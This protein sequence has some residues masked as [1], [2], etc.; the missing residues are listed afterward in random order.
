[1]DLAIFIVITLLVIGVLYYY[2]LHLVSEKY[3]AELKAVNK[4][5]FDELVVYIEG[6]LFNRPAVTIWNA[7]L[8]RARMLMD[9]KQ[10]LDMRTRLEAAVWSTAEGLVIDRMQTVKADALNGLRLSA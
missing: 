10:S 4:M 5:S 7:A 3:D 8:G 2:Y 1:M 9:Y 6:N